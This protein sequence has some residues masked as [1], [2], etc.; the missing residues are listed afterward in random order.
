[1]ILEGTVNHG[2]KHGGKT[3]AW[4]HGSRNRLVGGAAGAEATGGFSWVNQGAE[5]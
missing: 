5:S 1:M 4:Y 2:K 3:A